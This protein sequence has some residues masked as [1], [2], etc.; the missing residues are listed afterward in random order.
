MIIG[1]LSVLEAF[2]SFKQ[3]ILFNTHSSVTVIES[4]E[5]NGNLS[6]FGELESG[7]LLFLRFS[8]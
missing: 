8:S 7:E 5:V 4:T 3:L 6:L 1:I 2:L